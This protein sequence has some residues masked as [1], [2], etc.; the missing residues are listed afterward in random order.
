MPFLLAMEPLFRMFKKAQDLGLLEKVSKGCERF[1]VSLYADDDAMFI[2]PTP[3]DFQVSVAIL[4]LFVEASGLITNMDKTSFYPIQCQQTSLEFLAQ[5]NLYVSSFPCIYLGLPLHFKKLPK[6]LLQVL[7]E[8]IANRLLGW[9]RNFLTYL[10]REMLIK[11]V[12][13]TMPTFFLTIFKM[14][15]WGFARIDKFRMSFL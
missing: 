8:K 9:Q 2:K 3:H 1:R 14:P 10:G 13:T 6:S 12:L 7:I 11:S 15:K 4:N 5:N